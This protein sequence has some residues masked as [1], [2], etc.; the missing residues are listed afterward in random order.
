MSQDAA[1]VIDHARRPQAREIAKLMEANAYRHRIDEVFADSVEMMALSMSNAADPAQAEDREARYMEIVGRYTREE[2]ERVPRMFALLVE[3]LEEAPGDVLGTVF[4]ELE[5]GSAA[6]GQFFTPYSVCAVMAQMTVGDG[7]DIRAKIREIGF[8]RLQEP[9]VGAGAMVI[10]FAECLR[11]AQIN[12]QQHLHVVAVDVDPRAVHMA[13]VQFSLLHIPA[14]VYLGN[15]LSLKMTQ[16]WRTP[17]HMM[18][19][20]ETML[21]RGYALGSEADGADA[22]ELAEIFEQDTPEDAPAMP[23]DLPRPA[24]L[25]API[26]LSQPDQPDLFAAFG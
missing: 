16:A 8:I 4:G 9:A 12:Y 21:R 23:A 14:T 17:A 15:T 2:I 7:A 10:A 22:G 6:R 11:L 26:N 13:Y 24:A 19:L 5:Q 3:A 20:W 25:P 1:R 18:G